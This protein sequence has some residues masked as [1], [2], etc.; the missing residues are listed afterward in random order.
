M[1]LAVRLAFL[2]REPDWSP[3][4]RFGLWTLLGLAALALL[5]RPHEDIFGGEDPGAYL[6]AG[7]T[8]GRQQKFFEVDPLLAQVPPATRPDFYYG[9]AGYGTTKDACLWVREPDR[10]VVGPH[11]QPAYPLLIAL[12][13]RLAGPA[14]ALFVI[15]VFTL[16]L[17]LALRALAALLLSHRLAGLIAFLLFLLN[18]LT[19]WHG[20][21]S[22]PEIIAGFM[23][24]GGC[25]LLLNARRQPCWA[26]WPDLTLGAAAVCLAP[27]FHITAGYL[28]IPAALVLATIILRGR[29]DFLLFSLIAMAA[30]VAFTWQMKLITDYYGLSRFLDHL[31]FR[32]ALAYGLFA[33]GFAAL[34]AGCWL[35]RR[36][37]ARQGVADPEKSSNN[38]SEERPRPNVALQQESSSVVHSWRDALR[39]VRSCLHSSSSGVPVLSLVTAI[40]TTLLILAAALPGDAA[41]SRLLWRPIENYLYLA[42]FKTF[43]R[44]ISL[45]MALL[46]LAGWIVW[47]TGP[48]AGRRERIALAL[49]V[50]P[51]LFFSGS[52]RDF[53]MTRYWFVALLPM[54]ALALTALA[55]WLTSRARSAWAAVIAAA[56]I[57][58]LGGYH[59][60]QL[61]TVTDYR[62]LARY[63]RPYAELMQK[64]NGILLGE[65]SRLAAPLEHFFGIPTLGLDNERQ[66]DYS[67]AEQA[68]ETIMRKYPDHPAFFMTPFHEP[69]S[70]RFDFHLARDAEFKG[71]KLLQAR[72]G[73]PTRIGEHRLRLRLYRMRLRPPG[74]ASPSPS[75]PF[76]Y[77][78]DSG[79][80]GLRHFA[81]P[82]SETAVFPAVGPDAGRNQARIPLDGAQLVIALTNP[83]WLELSDLV[84]A[85]QGQP[86][87][88]RAESVKLSFAA[89]WTRARAEVFVPPSAQP[90]CLVLLATTPRLQ[91][92]QTMRVTI[93]QGAERYAALAPR[94]DQW[95]WHLI[96]LP[97][98]AAGQ[99]LTLASEPAWNPK[100]S[101]FPSDLGILVGHLSFWPANN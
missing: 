51:A 42:D 28:L 35:S 73:L 3:R 76:Q 74:A 24:F 60:M 31:I 2:G 12:V 99:W 79:N 23:F 88:V 17:A 16:G 69:I 71:R 82:R 89:R 87:A 18:P 41:A 72:Q 53:M 54:A 97:A 25:A 10:A 37:A 75:A 4:F 34:A 62:G 48:A 67:R 1:L 95:Q 55:C 29:A 78:M 94:P 98:S 6:N 70:E 20:R 8:Y 96:P 13:S 47:L 19:L 65:Y 39:R 26:R 36:A 52:I 30:L 92:G 83:P 61:V 14:S 91:G 93:S 44:M 81:N 27:F 84:I 5:F 90:G 100:L 50:F 15:P 57:I 7:I 32:P 77:Q 46:A 38:S 58:L 40:T 21:C 11:F 63:L 64:E 66:D 86:P 56:L 45:P 59:R 49:V 85:G 9:H 80:M 101:G 68:W 33:A 22:R 43:A